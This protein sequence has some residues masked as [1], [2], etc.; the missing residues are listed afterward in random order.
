MTDISFQ[1]IKE[2]KLASE[3]IRQILK[4]FTL[5][6]YFAN[7]IKIAKLKQQQKVH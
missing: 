4:T 1:S 2:K 6:R 5:N 7:D 3:L